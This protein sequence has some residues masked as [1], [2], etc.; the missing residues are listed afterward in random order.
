MRLVNGGPGNDGESMF[1]VYL[2]SDVWHG[3]VEGS[4]VLA[5]FGI[6]LCLWNG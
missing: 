4:P 6:R 5:P 2:S 1:A 3:M